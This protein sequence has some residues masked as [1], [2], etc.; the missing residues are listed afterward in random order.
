MT[1][2]DIIKELETKTAQIGLQLEQSLSQHNFMAGTK[3]EAERILNI[4]KT[5]TVKAVEQTAQEVLNGN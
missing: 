4:L 5:M 1:L 2:E 3:A